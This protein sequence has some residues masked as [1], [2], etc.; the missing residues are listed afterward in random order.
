MSFGQIEDQL[1][2][3]RENDKEIDL[4]TLFGT[5]SQDDQFT[6]PHIH[7]FRSTEFEDEPPSYCPCMPLVL[8][9]MDA[10]R[11]EVEELR[12]FLLPTGKS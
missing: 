9:K 10:L 1:R 4:S 11:A 8:S 2:N 12:Q 6:V 3:L 5:Q 7:R